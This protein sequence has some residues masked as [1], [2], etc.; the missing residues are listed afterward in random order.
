MRPAHPTEQAV[1]MAHYVTDTDGVGGR[2]REDD[3]HFRVR[4]RERFDTQPVDA[5]TDAY[6]YLVVRATLSGWDTNDFAGR[7][8]DALGV[9]RERVNWAGTKDKYAVTTQLFSIYGAD[10]EDLPEV[11]GADIEVV[12]RAGRSLEFGDLAGNEF[13]LIVSDA[14]APEN[15]TA[16]TEELHAFG[17]HEES[18]ADAAD[19]SS[20]AV[21]V[22]NFFGQQRFGSRRPVTHEVGLEIVRGSWEGAVMAYLGNPTDAEPEST[23]E[24]RRFIEETRD[25]QEAL[26]RFPNRLRY[27]RSLCHGLAEVDGDPEP[28]DFRA[29]LERLP[30]NLQRLFVH[31]AQSYAFNLMLSA[32]LERGLPFDE[33]VAGDVA[34]FADT[35][36]PA[37]L[38]LPD[39]DRL[40]RVTD[41][42]V[43]SVRRHCERGRAFVTAPLV[44]T[45]TELADGEQGEIERAVLDDL[46]L[47]PA[48]FDL[49]GEFYSSGTR[50]AILV[51][52][53]IELETDPLTLSFAL[54]KGSYAT[55]LLREYLKVDPV[56]L[57]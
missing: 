20:T 31:A 56:D 14:D 7:L 9:S 8:S 27:E 12:G 34:C 19:G 11:R 33:P 48:D 38:E 39:T 21:G 52:T 55:V 22:P 28:D 50:R 30:S 36:A 40:Q 6:P 54:P 26:E 4:E 17:G 18:D 32:R 15:A 25:W 35:D 37:G 2:L 16:I 44:G 5:A 1:G 43:R 49:P 47:E 3:D 13:E 42:R 23:Q 46:G 53:T 45:E 57:G 41:R 24:A 51:R 29:A 10:P